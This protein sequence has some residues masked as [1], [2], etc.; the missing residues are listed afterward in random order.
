MKLAK[1]NMMVSGI[2]GS[3]SLIAY[4]SPVPAV[5]LTA[6]QMNAVLLALLGAGVSIFFSSLCTY[7]YERKRL[8]N[9]FL[10]AAERV[11]SGL[12]GLK[13]CA[14][15]SIG[16]SREASIRLFKEY[17]EEEETLR[18]LG[19]SDSH[20]AR[21]RLIQTIERCDESQIGAFL[22][23]PHSSFNRC[24]ERMKR[25][26][27]SIVDSYLCLCGDE[28][29]YHDRLLGIMEEVDYVCLCPRSLRR[30]QLLKEAQEFVSKNKESLDPV[31]RRCQL[32]K[33]ED[34]GYGE[35]LADILEAEKKWS[36]NRVARDGSRAPINTYADDLYRPI[37]EFAS[38]STSPLR[39]HY[40]SKKPGWE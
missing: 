5:L 3:V 32:F 17:F 15:E 22:D 28:F 40:C 26:I 11:L 14:I 34:I 25:Q 36:S 31:V 27:E 23:T 13:E 35:I 24:I 33:H 19:P 6:E 7:R 4:L 16:E 29:E 12:G 39:A 30:R 20:E 10:E 37:R 9:A 18:V 38:L 8:E 2:V 1:T 21:D